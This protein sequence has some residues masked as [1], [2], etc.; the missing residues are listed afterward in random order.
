[1]KSCQ[2]LF[3]QSA[4]SLKIMELLLLLFTEK[5]ISLLFIYS[6]VSLAK[7]P[8]SPINFFSPFVPKL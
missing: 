7:F 5:L 8:D 2:A 1:M 3:S 6:H 4:L